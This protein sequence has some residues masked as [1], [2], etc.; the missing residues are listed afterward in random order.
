MLRLPSPG[1]WVQDKSIE[2]MKCLPTFSTFT[3][4]PITEKKFYTFPTQCSLARRG[5][6]FLSTIYSSDS[7]VEKLLVFKCS[8]WREFLNIHLFRVSK[9][10]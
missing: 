2:E 7:S 10:S 1:L 5:F 9:S 4:L 6:T 8:S 3:T